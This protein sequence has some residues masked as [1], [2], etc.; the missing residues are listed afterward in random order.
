MLYDGC[1][2]QPSA[3]TANRRGPEHLV[4]TSKNRNR[5]H[6]WTAWYVSR[7]RAKR[8]SKCRCHCCIKKPFW[9]L[10]W[11]DRSGV[12]FCKCFATPTRTETRQRH[13]R[14]KWINKTRLCASRHANLFLLLLARLFAARRLGIFGVRFKHRAFDL[15]VAKRVL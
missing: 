2:E 9:P 13:C 10:L 7:R 8:E 3:F 6:G 15:L 14:K 1:I 12:V 4:N 11:Q 5:I